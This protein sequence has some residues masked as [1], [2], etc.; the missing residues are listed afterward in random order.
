MMA[1]SVLSRDTTV[2]T[3]VPAIQDVFCM[4]GILK[5]MGCRCTLAGGEL[6]ISPADMNRTDLP[7]EHRAGI[8]YGTEIRFTFRPE[9]IHL[10]DP[11]T[12]KNLM[13]GT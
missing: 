3:N 7:E 1:A 10:F 6:T 13:Y 5:F 4:M 11:Q 8:P 9:L 2:L 12:E